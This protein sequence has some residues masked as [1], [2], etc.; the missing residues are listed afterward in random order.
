MDYL[1]PDLRAAPKHLGSLSNAPSGKCITH[2]GRTPVTHPHHMM[3]F[4][5]CAPVCLAHG[6]E[7]VSRLSSTVWDM[8]LHIREYPCEVL[9]LV[10][11]SINFKNP[12]RS[13]NI[14][15]SF[16]IAF[17]SAPE[18][19]ICTQHQRTHP[20]FSYQLAQEIDICLTGKSRR[21]PDNKQI[22]YAK[23]PDPLYPLAST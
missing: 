21:I 13:S 15:R 14:A 20:Q 17:K 5:P 4:C 19:R 3:L 16:D 9:A 8:V 11:N 12:Y 2:V 22:L 1:A 6:I 23:I 10:F 7:R 18:P